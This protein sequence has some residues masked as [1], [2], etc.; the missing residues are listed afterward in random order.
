MV[1]LLVGLGIG[2]A[3]ALVFVVTLLPSHS[4]GGWLRRTGR[5]GLLAVL[6]ACGLALVGGSLAFGLQSWALAAPML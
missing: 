3:L 4:G 1:P 2:L 5:S 6:G